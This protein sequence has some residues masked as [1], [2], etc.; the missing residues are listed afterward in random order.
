MTFRQWRQEQER[1]SRAIESRPNVTMKCLTCKHWDYE[2]YEKKGKDRNTCGFLEE[3]GPLVKIESHCYWVSTHK[4][5]SCAG[6]EPR[7]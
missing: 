3:G 5:F 6:Y 7:S 4:D 2:E 1:I